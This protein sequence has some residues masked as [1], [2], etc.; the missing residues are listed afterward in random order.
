[1]GMIFRNDDVS[2]NTDIIEMREIYNVLFEEFPSCSIISGVNI[3]SRSSNN[4][5]VYQDLPLKSKSLDYF[6]KVNNIYHPPKIYKVTIAS[7]GLW[8]FD[9]TK[10]SKDLKKASI[11]T[12]CSLLGTSMFIPPFNKWDD[13]MDKICQDNGIEMIKSDEH[14]WK[15]ADINEF[16]PEHNFWYFH[17]WR[18]T[19]D[20]MRDYLKSNVFA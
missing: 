16:N 10:V 1:M 8:H 7:H 19:A 17:S 6:L 15:S 3:F 11:V 12:S 20:R 5:A 14:G 13:G 2:S 9:H 18:W 4:G